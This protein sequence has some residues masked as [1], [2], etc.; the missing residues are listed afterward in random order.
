MKQIGVAFSPNGTVSSTITSLISLAKQVPEIAGRVADVTFK[1][2]RLSIEFD[3]KDGVRDHL[4]RQNDMKLGISFKN[5]SL[6]VLKTAIIDLSNTLFSL[7]VKNGVYYDVQNLAV[8]EMVFS[9]DL[10]TSTAIQNKVSTLMN[11]KVADDKDNTQIMMDAANRLLLIDF[12][13]LVSSC[14]YATAA[15]KKENEL[16]KSST[17]EYTNAI[18]P[19]IERFI[20]IVRYYSPTHC[21]IAV[22]AERAEL[23]RRVVVYKDYKKNRDEKEKPQ[24][25]EQQFLLA[26]EL[27]EAMNIPMLLVETMEA[28]DVINSATLKWNSEKRGDVII[29]S[30]DKD[31]HQL[32]GGKVIQVLSGNVEMTRESFIEKFDLLPEQYADYKALCG[33]IGD[34]IP[35]V[36]GIGDKTAVKLL[37][38][39]STLEGVLSN[40]GQLKGKLKTNLENNVDVAIMSKKLAILYSDFPKINNL[41]FNELILK[42]NK[43]G[44]QRVLNRLEI[45]LTKTS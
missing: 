42:V 4:I 34:N 29:L 12:S 41:N 1:N 19:M 13:N 17:G 10:V 3:E 21:A 16:M 45:N 5:L 14:Y 11:N 15:G 6:S 7:Q 38:E 26:R 40:V 18:K 32:L 27:F 36:P 28:D 9:L 22:D 37:K 30:G 33:E 23:Y 24:S 44:M 2:R 20:N 35:G 8:N 31:L 39:Y 25:L 43:V